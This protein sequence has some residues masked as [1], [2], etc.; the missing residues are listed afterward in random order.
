MGL[1]LIQ[2]QVAFLEVQPEI[3]GGL[4]AEAQLSIQKTLPLA[5]MDVWPLTIAVSLQWFSSIQMLDLCLILVSRQ[6]LVI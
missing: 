5:Y 2:D 4:E 3:K 6:L 1:P